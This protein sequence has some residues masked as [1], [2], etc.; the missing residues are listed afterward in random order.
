MEVFVNNL[1]S[2]FCWIVV[3]FFG[4]LFFLIRWLES[5]RTLIFLFFVIIPSVFF[6]A[7][8]SLH[9]RFHISSWNCSLS[10]L[11]KLKIRFLH[12]FSDILADSFNSLISFFLMRPVKALM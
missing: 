5:L 9:L 12:Q 3:I 1:S 7:I 4:I 2:L 10:R 11:K 8:I 6:I